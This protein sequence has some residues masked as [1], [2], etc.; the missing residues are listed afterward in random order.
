[1]TEP[2]PKDHNVSIKDY[3]AH[4]NNIENELDTLKEDKKELNA[5]MKDNGVDLKAFAVALKQMRKPIEAELMIKVNS[6]LNDSDQL[7]LFALS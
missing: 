2:A 7:P 3:L 4:A 6:Y 5:E 1:M